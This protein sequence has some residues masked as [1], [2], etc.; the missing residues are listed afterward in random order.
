MH[1]VVGERDKTLQRLVAE[2]DL[3][4]N[5]RERAE[6][7]VREER[8]RAEA[9]AAELQVKIAEADQA[10]AVAETRLVES[11]R[12]LTDKND[13]VERSKKQLEDNFAHLA[14]KTLKEVSEQLLQLGQTQ[15]DGSKGEML[16]SLDTKRAEI[17]TLLT[18]LREMVSG[19][20]KELVQSEANRNEVYGGLQEQIRALLLV[21]ETAQR[22]TSRLATALQSPTVR[23]SWG[24]ITL[25]RCVELAGLVEYCDFFSQQTVETEEGRRLRPDML[26]RLPNSRVI[27]VDAK[28]PTHEYTLA[29][30]CT[31]EEQKRQ[32]LTAHSR[33]LR[34]HIDALSR[35]EYQ[36]NIGESLDFTVMF[37]PGEHFLSSALVTD[38]SIFE[39]AVERKV[40]VASPTVLLPL[41]RAIYAGWRAERTEENA[42]KMHDG[43]VELFNRFVKVM[44]DIARVGVALD[45]AVAKYNIAIRSI[46][47]RLWP[48]GTEL[49]RMAGSGKELG[50]L[51]Q[52]EAIPLESSKL[53]LTMQ[54]T[55]PGEVIPMRAEKD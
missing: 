21:Q 1:K 26:V 25:R 43:A 22:E 19:Y 54:P 17:E 3:A 16:Q 55:E 32:L 39:Y 40:Y 6:G 52:L 41:L 4:R 30:D 44:D 11:E 14:Q 28:A 47:T 33:N 2:R 51:E 48:K 27:A 31:D 37:L 35:K 50:T 20:R 46:D 18:P 9:V 12:L 53:R 29:A 49:Q 10:R 5:E 38:P 8:R 34:R 42:K 15:L 24:E 36:A 13:F 23:G 45:G 7:E